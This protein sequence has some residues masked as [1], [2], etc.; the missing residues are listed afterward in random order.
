MNNWIYTMLALVILTMAPRASALTIVKK[1]PEYNTGQYEQTVIDI[2]VKVTGGEIAYS[3]QLSKGQWH[4]TP[5]W[6]NISYKQVAVIDNLSEEQQYRDDTSLILRNG[7]AYKL[8]QNSEPAVYRYDKEKYIVQTET[9]F[10][11]QDRSGEWI[12]YDLDRKIKRY[13]NTQG[14][15]AQFTH[16]NEGQVS[17]VNDRFNKKIL[18]LTYENNR[19]KTV[20]DYAGRQVSYLWQGELLE[21]VTDVSG[22]QWLYSYDSYS[23]TNSSMVEQALAKV[24][25][26]EA[27][28][29]TIN[30][31]V[32]GGTVQLVCSGGG[33]GWSKIQESVDPDTGAVTI[34]VVATGSGE[35]SC[36]SRTIPQQVIF[37]SMIDQDG[38]K[39][40]FVYNYNSQYKAYGISEVDADGVKTLRILASDGS[41]LKL[42]KGDELVYSQGRVGNIKLSADAQGNKTTT[43]YDDYNNIIKVTNPDGSYRSASYHPAY[44]FASR[45]VDENGNITEI[46]YGDDGLPMEMVEAKGQ[47]EQL[48]TQYS[49][50][51]NQQLIS[52]TYSGQ[53]SE[54][55]TFTFEYDDYGNL[56][57]ETI[58]NTITWRYQDFTPE[59]QAKKVIDANGHIWL[60][61]YDAQERLTKE[62]DP[63]GNSQH[64]QYDKVGNLVKYTDAKQNQFT[65]SYNARDQIKTATDAFGKVRHYKINAQEVRTEYKDELGKTFSLVM[66][67]AGRP[68]A[69]VDGNNNVSSFSIGKDEDTGEGAF[70][71][72]TKVVY[73]TYSQH[74]QYNN[75]RQVTQLT[76]MDNDQVTSMSFRYDPLG[77]LIAETDANGHSTYYS[78]DA[79][80]NVI[81][82]DSSGFITQYQYNVFGELT[83]FT[84]R[85]NYVTELAYDSFGRLIKKSRQGYGDW[86]YTYDDNGNLLSVIDPNGQQLSYE[87]DN[88]NRLVSE[89]HF[90]QVLPLDP[91]EAEQ[92]LPQQTIH[93][94]YDQNDNLIQWQSGELSANYSRDSN[95]RLISETVN[96]P[97]FSKQ[98][99]YSYYDNGRVKS[100][101][102]PDGTQ[103]SYEYDNNNQLTRLQ[104]PGEGSL[105]VNEFKWTAPA[106]ETFPGGIE[107]QKHY[108][109]LL[110]TEKLTVLAPGEQKVL[111]LSYQYGLAKEISQ[112]NNDGQITTYQYDSIYRLQQA[113]TT[114]LD[115]SKRLENYQL[116]ANS[117][118]LASHNQDHWHYNA[119]G[120]ITSTGEGLAATTYTHDANGNLTLRSRENSQL[121]FI[122]DGQNRL[123]QVENESA[124]IIARY[125]YDPFDR[126]LSKTVAGITTYYLYSNEGLIAE[127]N[128]QGEVLT[129][130]GYRPD[131]TWG[132]DPVF[133]ETASA[134]NPNTKRYFYYHN[135][136]LGTPYK[137]TDNTGYVVWQTQFD[138]FG[139]ALLADN[140]QI[141]NNLRFP[142]QYFDA[143]TGLHYNWRRY[144]D[145]ELGRYITADPI[146]LAGGANLYTYV[147]GD[148]INRIDPNGEC[149]L[150]GIASGIIMNEAI[151]QISGECNKYGFWDGLADGL[152]F[153]ALSK[154]NRLRKLANGPCADNSFTGDTLVHTEQGL[155]PIQDI[156]IGDKV[157]AFAEWGTEGALGEKSQHRI[158]AVTDIITNTKEY[159][160][161]QLTLNSGEVIETTDQHPFYI[162]G[163]GWVEAEDLQIGQPLYRGD[164]GTIA[165]AKITRETRV[166]T[167]YNLTVAK[168]H[169]YYVG[170]DKVLVHNAGPCPLGNVST[171]AGRDHI[172][173]T[174]IKPDG[175]YVG[176]ASAPS[177]LNLSPQDILS[178]RYNNNFDGF[179]SAPQPYDNKWSGEGGKNLARGLEQNLH[180][181]NVRNG[182][183]SNRQNPVGPN[184][185]KR[186]KYLD[187][188]RN[189]LKRKR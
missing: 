97:N 20:T 110:N 181:N 69:R 149:A 71:D 152:C 14:V 173:Y 9:G 174:G 186:N 5:N 91:L 17:Q 95:N 59:G 122:Y 124:Q 51:D 156:K 80:G 114:Q 98:Y 105:R 108:T 36:S 106:K 177:G 96:Y 6:N 117:N 34:E 28:V 60:Y 116:D 7:Y 134:L 37:E 86:L 11:W 185:L 82:E 47:L 39:H 15:T 113:E 187:A 118:R 159:Q 35:S 145:P 129:R 73:P 94:Q 111:E 150:A 66:D 24:T 46:T 13:G 3:R 144:Y 65:Y 125:Q 175:P 68:Q 178:R 12:E 123:V 165:I 19:I 67:R 26:P 107:R 75:R 89:H 2:S 183:T 131:T 127:Y 49:Y 53:G 21:Q 115:N 18:T 50:D 119:A 87:Y 54:D 88:A 130:Y 169:T 160:L 126:R 153:G 23:P 137:I 141:S 8:E 42:F 167:V 143:E 151:N 132:T 103:Y 57:K 77:Q 48:T 79:M 30:N 81:H 76:L 25:D 182:N 38:H 135:D 109:G 83:T 176:Y 44:N 133:I 1:G 58:N 85:N 189:Y 84:D 78:Y 32:V 63:L 4:F 100:L 22:Y 56:T 101:T 164:L 93:Y 92:V 147:D 136:Q 163:R 139:N 40:S 61:Q 72:L 148:P 121:T 52:L 146:D 10:R 158:D 170:V 188:V 128:A 171:G 90:N 142:G 155:V 184:N 45:I 112:R 27:R 99:Q 166:E 140:N 64:Y 157:H 70:D 154:A 74:Y 33:G 31:Q 29:T 102:M 168:S 41:I 179:S 55:R 120:Q 43:E 62:T 161:V 172:V 162:L 104:I 16:N 180:E 138:S